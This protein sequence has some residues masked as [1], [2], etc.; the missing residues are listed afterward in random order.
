MIRKIS[1]LCLFLLIVR[2]ASHGQIKLKIAL[3][4]NFLLKNQDTIY[5]NKKV[6]FKIHTSKGKINSK[7]KILYKFSNGD[8]LTIQIKDLYLKDTLLSFQVWTLKKIKNKT[9]NQSSST[10]N[11]SVN[12]IFGENNSGGSFYIDGNYYYHSYTMN[13]VIK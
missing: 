11:T 7:Y 10:M 8:K 1:I 2:V 12:K 9:Y 13:S 5:K 3:T 6:I 4:S